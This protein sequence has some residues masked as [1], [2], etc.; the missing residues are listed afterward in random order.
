[1]DVDGWNA[2]WLVYWMICLIF[3]NKRIFQKPPSS[4]SPL[5]TEWSSCGVWDRAA[6][7]SHRTG[8][9]LDENILAGRGPCTHSQQV[10]SRL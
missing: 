3:S 6:G 7:E 5:S 10:E 9:E 1:M 2:D 8:S 4:F